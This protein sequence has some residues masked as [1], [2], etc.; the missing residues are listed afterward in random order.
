MVRVSQHYHLGREQA[1]LEFVDVDVQTDVPLFIDP[2]AIRLLTTSMARECASLLQNFFQRVIDAIQQGNHQEAR[3]LLSTLNELNETRLGFSAAGARGH[4]M[5][6]GLA[7][8]LEARL[9]TSK[10]I[11]TGLLQDLEET[12]LFVPGV[13]RDIVSDIVT[14]IILGPL[15]SFT[16][17]MCQKYGIQAKPGI[18]YYLWNKQH[19]WEA[20][21]EALPVAGGRPLILVP[22]AFVRRRRALFDAGGY[23]N[24]YVLPYLQ[25]QHLD[26]NSDLVR[27]LKDGSVRP[28]TKKTLQGQHPNVKQTN[29]DYTEAEPQLLA[30]YRGDNEE[31]FDPIGL[32]ELAV[33]VGGQQPDFDQLL[34]DVLICEKGADGAGRYQRAVEKLLTALFYP[35]LDN[36]KLEQPTNQGR[37]RIDIDY[38]NQATRGFFH[39]LHAVHGVHCSLVAVECKNYTKDPANP[40]FDQLLGRF[41]VQRGYVGVM[42]YRSSADK[43]LIIQRCRDAALAG[44]GY[45][46]PLDDDDLTALVEERK[47]L[48]DG[49]DFIFLHDRFRELIN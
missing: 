5:G 44:Q 24:F 19:G 31:E 12:A 26:A 3:E 47:V 28:P 49:Q 4:G 21:T 45:I 16:V 6:H 9:Q 48:V 33:G 40:E 32:T 15:V 42:C 34:Q 11:Q 38:E 10:A 29:T 2:G 46:L 43:Q 22:R 18:A 1:S 14:N 30:R 25:Q 37:K 35:A 7:Q 41:T 39:W 27:I 36:P 13:D 8:A 23:Y 20:A 17:T